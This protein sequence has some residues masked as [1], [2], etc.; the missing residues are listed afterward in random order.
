MIVRILLM[1]DIEYQQTK[2]TINLN[3]LMKNFK[4]LYLI[5]VIY[6][7]Y[8]KKIVVLELIDLIIILDISIQIVEVAVLV[9]IL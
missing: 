2:E 5:V 3:Y 7:V 8:Q 9:V 1:Q 4:K 6:A